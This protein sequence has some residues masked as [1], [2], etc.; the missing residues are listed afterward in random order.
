MLDKPALIAPPLGDLR[1]I[2]KF[3]IHEAQLLDERR[4]E[5]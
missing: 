2:E 5:E 1:T 3:L 4:F